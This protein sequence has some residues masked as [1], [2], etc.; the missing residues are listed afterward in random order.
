[1]AII[2][3]TSGPQASLEGGQWRPSS[4]VTAPIVNSVENELQQR[5]RD[6]SQ[7]N[8]PPQANQS[9]QDTQS[10]ESSN[11]ESA[12][13][14]RMAR[15]AFEASDAWMKINLRA[16][17][18]RNLRHYHSEHA[19][20][21]P[22]LSETNKHRSSY[23]WPKTRTLVR[24]IQA[25]A[26]SAFFASADVVAIE[27]ED[28]DDQQQNEAA[29]LMKELVNY[30]LANSIPWYQILLGGIQEVAVL[31]MVVSHQSWEYREKETVIGQEIDPLTGEIVELYTTE[32]IVDKPNVRIVPAEN[33]RISPAS[34]WLDP[35]NSSPYLIEMIPM[36]LVDVETKIRE[37][38]DSK[39]GEPSWKDIGK[40]M[41]MAAGERGDFDTTRRARAGKNHLDPKS[42][43]MESV[44]DFKMIWVHRN[45]V[46]YNGEDWLYYTAGTMLMLSEPVLLS[47]VI[48]WANGKRDYASGKLEVETDKVYPS[49]AVSLIAGLQKSLNE[50]KNQRIDNVRQVLNRRYLY[51]QGS[52]VDVRALSRNVPGGLIGISA[53][54][55][56][57]S[58]VMP[59]ATADVTSSSYQEEDRINL[60]ADDLSGSMAGSTV[61]S[62]RKMNETVGG[63][64]MMQ[65]AGN[66]V[67]EMELRTITK[68]WIETVLQQIVQLEAMYETDIIAITVAS[69]KAKLLQ[70]LP[71]YFDHKF[72]VTVNVGAGAVSPSQRIQKISTAISTVIQLVPDAAA[73]INGRE[74]AKEV[75]GAAGY[76]NGER[77]FNFD[78]AEEMKANPQVDPKIELAQKQMEEKSKF[79]QGKLEVAQAKIQL[80][81]DKLTMAMK[82]ME[83]KIN[84]LV[85]QTATTNVTAVYEATQA[86]GVIAQNPGIAPVSDE[87]LASSGFADHNKA[88]IVSEVTPQPGMVP[89]AVMPEAPNY[90]PSQAPSGKTGLRA[91][92]E[93][94]EIEARAKGGPVNQG[95]PYLV[96]EKGPEVIVPNQSGTV[97]PNNYAP[98]IPDTGLTQPDLTQRHLI[99][100]DMSAK[101]QGFYGNVSGTSNPE[102]PAVTEYSIGVGVPKD[103]QHIPG[104]NPSTAPLQLEGHQKYYDAP[105]IVPGLN[106]EQLQ[107]IA[108][109]EISPELY[110]NA[111]RAAADRQWQGKPVFAK[112]TEPVTEYPQKGIT[113]RKK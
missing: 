13:W 63:M 19:E 4:S 74:I 16:E 106:P 15:N 10:A 17:W 39:N 69:K 30:R 9:T 36:F 111:E 89:P 44:D 98:A 102:A 2:S 90:H 112:P 81:N 40:N 103:Y 65:S 24:D 3:D 8:Q 42:Y 38:K 50:I 75:F 109:G 22:I 54:G 97:V 59:L 21:S 71:E 55:A 25:A 73:A 95:Q 86:A 33:L 107:N 77:F 26:T 66:R 27:A 92:I 88:P 45:I 41:L 79:E 52:Q 68:T 61:N 108:G 80:E 51:R 91:G 12:D 37:G 105:S 57:D 23:F 49:S 32:V 31:G 99:R 94:P 7:D 101:G 82:E 87:I 56:L 62:N 104:L 48:P 35:I 46:R 20:G 100:D 11:T 58:H 78:R 76:D 83:A 53:P 70:I 14:L 47:S 67:R 1:M 96:G 64:E 113:K 60:A 72:S 93:T 110:T 29:S 18:S 5:S 85:A 28:Q 34:D 6:T 43:Q 84:L